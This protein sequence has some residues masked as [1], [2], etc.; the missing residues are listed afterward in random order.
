MCTLRNFPNQIEHCIEWGRDKFNTLFT[1]RA[2]D[3][4]SFLENQ[5]K[6]VAE[7]KQNNTSSGELDKLQEIK[8]LIDLKVSADYSKCVAVAR[9]LFDSFY[10]H[11]IR[12]LKSI[13]PDDHLDSAGNKF[14]SGP[15]RAPDAIAFNAQDELHLDFVQACANLVAFNLGIPMVTDREEARAAAL[16]YEGK[17]YVKKEIKVETPEEAK[18]RE[19][20]GKPAP[21][22]SAVPGMTD[23]ED[24]AKLM[25]DL[26]ITTKTVKAS[27]L[28]A[29]DFEK[30]DDSN[31]HIAFITA[32]SNL[33]ARN[34]KIGEA[35]FHKTK[36]IAGKII[37]AIATTTAM[38]TGAVT[39]E[40]FKYV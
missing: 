33:R 22:E 17:P 12:D 27:A 25:E 40:I 21:T 6:F 4:I 36:M 9:D 19:A 1:D 13:F 28:E 34:Y 18:E 32:A 8:N 39:N 38:I 30:D 35:D 31:F 11:S 10:D 15:K 3:A 2:Q 14:W 7:L 23:Q 26:S 20:Q 5:E 29:A 16:A 24:I 37:P